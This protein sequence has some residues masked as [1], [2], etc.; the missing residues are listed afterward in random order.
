MKKIITA[1]L[2]VLISINT[3]KSQDGI[4]TKGNNIVNV[5]YGVNL[6]TAVLKNAY[7]NAQSTDVSVKSF[8]PIGLVYEHLVVD[9]VGLGVELGYGSTT[10]AFKDFYTDNNGTINTYN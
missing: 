3:L 5:Y 10:V 4:A 8:G 7:T 6:L 2:L 1:S 9:K